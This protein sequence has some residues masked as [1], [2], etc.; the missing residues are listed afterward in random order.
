MAKHGKRSRR[1][2]KFR[3]YLAGK[4]RHLLQ[5]GTLG[6]TTI[7]ST[8]VV[9]VLTEKAYLTSVRLAWSLVRMTTA[10][11]DGPIMVG[12]AHPDYSGAEVEAWIENQA[13]WEE[14]DVIGQEVG[15]RK[16][17]MVGVFLNPEG[18][19]VVSRLN[20][21]KPITTKCGWQLQTGQSVKIWAYNLGT[22]ALATTDPEV[23]AE[24]HANLWP[25]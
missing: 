19:D 16:I 25:N 22:S 9:D 10:T 15:R 5:L 11:N 8:N 3:R 14:G 1:G 6:G 13:S 21:G 4:I 12:V 18:V 7:I 17:R 20:D 23:R 24:G 2:R